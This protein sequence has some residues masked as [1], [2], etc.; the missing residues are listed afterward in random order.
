MRELVTRVGQQSG[1]RG[2]VKRVGYEMSDEKV[3]YAMVCGMC[4]YE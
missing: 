1:L 3:G 4:V 2:W